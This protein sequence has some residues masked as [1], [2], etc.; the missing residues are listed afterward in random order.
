MRKIIFLDIDWVMNTYLSEEKITKKHVN[1]LKRIIEK[2]DAY[3]VISSDWKYI[4]FELYKYWND[5]YKLPAILGFTNQADLV[6]WGGYCADW[7]DR[8]KEIDIFIQNC[9]ET[10]SVD[11]KYV[12]IDDL[13]IPDDNLFQTKMMVWLT[14]DIADNIISFLNK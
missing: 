2:T 4:P 8:K 10:M 14:D 12:I 9:L 11:F 7:E 1:I 13:D 5:I 6:W 3:I